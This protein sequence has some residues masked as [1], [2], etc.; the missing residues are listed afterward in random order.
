MQPYSMKGNLII[1]FASATII[2]NKRKIRK[3]FIFFFFLS[4]E[5]HLLVLDYY[6]RDLLWNRNEL[7]IFLHT[8]HIAVCFRNISW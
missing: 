6:I 1:S 8:E 5:F 2:I 4:L 7:L 3:G